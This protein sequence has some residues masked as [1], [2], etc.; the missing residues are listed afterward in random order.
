M[1]VMIFA[2]SGAGL[3]KFR[4]ELLEELLK[5]YEVEICLPNG[6]YVEEMSD[7]GCKFIA[8]D[9]LERRGKNPL[10]DFELFKFYR[11]VLKQSKPD[12]VLTYTIK[13]NVYGG[14]ACGMAKIPYIANIT[15]LGTAVEN[16]GVMQKVTLILYKLGLMRAQK[17]FFQNEENRKFMLKFGIAKDKHD[18]LP[19]S[20]VNLNQYQLF[21]YPTSDTIDFVFVA[22]VM[23]EKGID[24]Y[25]DAAKYIKEKYPQTRFHV[26]GGC[27][28]KYS[29]ILEKLHN[30]GVIIYHGVVK[31][32]AEMYKKASCIIHPSYYPEGLSNVLLESSASGRAIIT[33]NRP[34]CGEVID[35]GINGF[36]CKQKDSEDLIKQIEKF[37]LLSWEDRKA[38]GLAGRK[39][40]EKSFNR[41]IV[42][43]KYL[44]EINKSKASL[45]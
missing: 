2:N 26:C 3:Y 6:A 20:G 38:M 17:V 28:E 1:K 19:G 9:L 37:L 45:K 25:L 29:G 36:V 18:L 23:K 34:G 33:T 8:C 12:V 10:K 13:P 14:M 30:E 35:D 24:N 21:D 43:D 40:V 4:K 44:N 15:G 16:P 7:M 22:R 31:N 39:K 41:K 32:M 42:I 5:L 27:D 11:K